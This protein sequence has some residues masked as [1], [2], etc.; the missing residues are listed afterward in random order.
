VVLLFSSAHCSL[1]A[2]IHRKLLTQAFKEDVDRAW[3]RLAS[4]KKATKAT[5]KL[6]AQI[7]KA[8]CLVF[9]VIPLM[10]PLGFDYGKGGSSLFPFKYSSSEVV[11][12]IVN[13]VPT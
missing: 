7:T 2:S 6:D 3:M 4:T 5:S 10:M 12:T 9:F 13:S 8:N 11:K 1:V